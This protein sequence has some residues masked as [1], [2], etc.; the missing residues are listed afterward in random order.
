MPGTEMEDLTRVGLE[1]KIRSRTFRKRV[2]EW[3]AWVRED[4][5][6][7]W[8]SDCCILSSFPVESEVWLVQLM[9]GQLKSPAKTIGHSF[10]PFFVRSLRDLSSSLRS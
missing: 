3:W 1:K 9:L 8:M 4:A 5:W 6:V 10:L 7:I 2:G